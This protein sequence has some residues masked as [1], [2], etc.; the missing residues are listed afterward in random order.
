LTHRRDLVINVKGRDLDLVPVG[1][2]AVLCQV[3][4]LEHGSGIAVTVLDNLVQKLRQILRDQTFSLRASSRKQRGSF[5][6]E[7]TN[8]ELLLSIRE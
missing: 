8:T 1:V 5:G 4:H 6:I 3:N 7:I 2:F